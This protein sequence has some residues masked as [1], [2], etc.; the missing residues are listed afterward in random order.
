M[1]HLVAG[2]VLSL[3]V[4]LPAT[5]DSYSLEPFKDELF[6]YRNILESSNG[7]DVLLVEYNQKRDLDERDITRRLKVDPK[8]VSLETKAVEEDLVM[9][10]GLRR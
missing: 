10:N 8:Y 7:G 6:A 4:A 5:A 1:K 9:R 2:T 3:A